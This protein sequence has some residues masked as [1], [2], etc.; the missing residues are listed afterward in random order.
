MKKLFALLKRIFGA[1]QGPVIEQGGDFLEEALESYAAKNPEQAAALVSS[2]HSWAPELKD[3]AAKS[4]TDW[5]DKA[6]AEIQEEL[7]EFAVRHNL[8]L[9]GPKPEPQPDPG[10]DVEG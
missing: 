10:P 1:V 2:L 5:D 3:L 6:V 9:P 7:L 4:K 8:Q